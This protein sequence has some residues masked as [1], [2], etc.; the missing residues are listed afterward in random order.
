MLVPLRIR[1][2]WIILSVTSLLL[3]RTI[4]CGTADVWRISTS[5]SFVT[6]S[7]LGRT[8]ALSI[9]SSVI[10]SFI[11]PLT[12]STTALRQSVPWVTFKP[13]IRRL[14]RRW[15]CSLSFD[16]R[17]TSRTS[18]CTAQ[19][20]AVRLAIS[21]VG[22][23]CCSLSSTLSILS[24]T[25]CMS[26]YR[27]AKRSR[28][29][30]SMLFNHSFLPRLFCFYSRSRF[31]INLMEKISLPIT[32]I[33]TLKYLTCGKLQ[34]LLCNLYFAFIND[35]CTWLLFISMQTST[36]TFNRPRV[37]IIFLTTTNSPQTVKYWNTEH[38]VYIRS[39]VCHLPGCCSTEFHKT[40]SSAN[41]MA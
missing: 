6:V 9:S 41:K 40:L 4:T 14:S 36:T 10:A 29:V 34:T 11:V 16:A 24:S 19:S 5:G 3:N 21:L 32:Q 12:K 13:L 20:S 26:W 35:T 7:R 1:R 15:C 33:L 8:W 27:I 22:S 39:T 38:L 18:V 25:F 30:N 37:R 2:F 31:V 17:A 23:L 28:C